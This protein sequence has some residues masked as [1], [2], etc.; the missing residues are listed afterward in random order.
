[1]A[2]SVELGVEVP[3]GFETFVV[4]ARRGFAD[5]N[6]WTYIC[7]D[8]RRL[9]VRLSVTALRGAQGEVVGFLGIAS[10][11]TAVKRSQAELIEAKENAERAMRAR[12]DFLARMSHE[13][14][15]PMNGI[16]GMVELA[17]QTELS[18]EQRDYLMTTRTS[19]RS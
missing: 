6:E 17:L 8:G 1:R 10:D 16:L 3:V 14:R 9:P 11:I 4:R 12:A 18:V 7:K 19:A 13:I 2:L 5:Q 15:T